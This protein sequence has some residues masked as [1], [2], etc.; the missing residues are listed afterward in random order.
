MPVSQHIPNDNNGDVLRR[1]LE[2]GDDLTQPRKI[3]F[4]FIFENR[5]KAIGF[6][7]V[8]DDKELTVSIH[9]YEERSLWNVT[10]SRYMIPSHAIVTTLEKRLT[11]AAHPFGGS[12][13]GWGCMAVKS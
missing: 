8:L 7:E 3:D 1:L 13:D 5:F 2:C 10:V 4:E 9:W 12:A 11:D 6:A